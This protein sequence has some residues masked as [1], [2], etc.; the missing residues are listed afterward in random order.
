M[1]RELRGRNKCTIYV[2]PLL[3]LNSGSFDEFVESYIDPGGKHLCVEVR[4]MRAQSIEVLTH[5]ALRCVQGTR[6]A[7]Q[8]WFTIPSQWWMD[9]QLFIE[10]KY[11]RMSEESKSMIR[12]YSGLAYRM[13]DF[14][15]YELH[16]DY[17]LMALDKNPLLRRKWEMLV[18][19]GIPE[20]LDLMQPPGDRDFRRFQI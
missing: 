13:V 18:G 9:V 14:D 12:T 4:N 11:S 16:T 8:I 3:S 19:Q 7:A 15:G 17:R 2:L 1:L 6:E 5:P 20:S 10:G